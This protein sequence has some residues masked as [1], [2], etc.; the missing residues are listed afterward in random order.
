MN[1]S[2]KSSRG[3]DN[4]N[5]EEIKKLSFWDSKSTDLAKV[6]WCIIYNTCVSQIVYFTFILLDFM[7]CTILILCI[8]SKFESVH[9]NMTLIENYLE[10]TGFPSA[11]LIEEIIAFI[12]CLSSLAFLAVLFFRRGKTSQYHEKSIFLKLF[13]FIM[14]LYRSL[15]QTFVILVI[16][17]SF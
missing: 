7:F 1:Q 2:K 4:S 9:L 15:F 17:G 8:F 16:T 14:A 13:F 10:L 11:S 6:F 5:E 12:L 3:R